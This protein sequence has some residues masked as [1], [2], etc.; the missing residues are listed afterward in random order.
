MKA[1]QKAVEVSFKRRGTLLSENI[2][3][4]LRS[5]HTWNSCLAKAAEKLPQARLL[6]QSEKRPTRL[7]AVANVHSDSP[8]CGR[9]ARCQ[10]R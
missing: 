8:I 3:F 9:F 5:V 4:A 2:P 1:L 7:A 6:Y 10:R